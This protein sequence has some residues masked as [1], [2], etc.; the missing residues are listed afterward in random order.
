MSRTPMDAILD[1]LD[2]RC[3]ACGAKRGECDC[4]APCAHGEKYRLD[5]AVCTPPKRKRRGGRAMTRHA[6]KKLSTLYRAA[7]AARTCAHDA[8]QGHYADD[9]IAKELEELHQRA[10]E[11]A[12]RAHRV[13]LEVRT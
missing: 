11:L 7:Q 10:V 3:T 8:A 1:R 9:R 4:W 12:N 13:L 2:F 6:R 5:C